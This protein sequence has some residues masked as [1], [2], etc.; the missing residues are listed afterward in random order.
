VQ[1][2]LGLPDRDYYLKDDA[3]FV[4]TRTKYRAYVEQMLKMA[5]YPGRRQS[6]GRDRR[7]R[8]TRSPKSTGRNEKRRDV[9]ATYNPK[10][11]AELKA[12]V[13]DFRGKRR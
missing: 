13:P 6:G 1:A 8:A 10:S 4:E 3:K 7:R 2:G 12:A 9:E 5:N 11:L